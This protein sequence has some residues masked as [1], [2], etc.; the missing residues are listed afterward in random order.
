MDQLDI[1]EAEGGSADR[2][3][4]IHTQEEKDFGLNIAVRAARRLDRVRPCRARAKDDAVA[5]LILRALEAGLGAQLL[6]SHDRGWYDPALPGG[7]TPTPYTHLSDVMLPML[8][9][10]GSTRR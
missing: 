2:F 7:G 3:I 4:S 1:I 6:L 10:A 8:R 9:A 5:E